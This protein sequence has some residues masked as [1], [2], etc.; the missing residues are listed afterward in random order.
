MG[1]G[2]SNQNTQQTTVQHNRNP[3]SLVNFKYEEK[4][5]DTFR[6]KAEKIHQAD[7]GLNERQPFG[8]NDSNTK[9]Y[10]NS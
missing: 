1:D 2:L 9:S 6:L 10:S 7:A 5:D 3:S 8:E 4:S